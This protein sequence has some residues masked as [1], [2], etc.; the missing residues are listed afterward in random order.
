MLIHA[1][2]EAMDFSQSFASR[3]QRPSHAKVR[4]TT[5]RRIMPITG[6]ETI[7]VPKNTPG[8]P[9]ESATGT[10]PSAATYVHQRPDGFPDPF[11]CGFDVAVSEMSV[12]QGHLHIG[13]SEQPRD[14]RH[15]R[16]VHHGMACHGMAQVVNADILNA[17]FASDAMP[18]PEV[19]T[20]R[21]D[22]RDLSAL[23]R[24]SVRLV[25]GNGFLPAPVAAREQRD[26]TPFPQLQ[27]F[28]RKKRNYIR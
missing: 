7:A 3:R 18:E 24:V 25:P 10:L 28:G 2:L 9:T 13:M 14:H 6:T 22:L 5:H 12:T 20:A 23:T 21:T 17:G 19:Q 1:S 8:L 15:R 27:I 26:C 4:S 16:S 11:G